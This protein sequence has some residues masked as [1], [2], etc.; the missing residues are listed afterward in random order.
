MPIPFVHKLNVGCEKRNISNYKIDSFKG[1]KAI[2][3]I[4]TVLFSE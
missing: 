1:E 4:S 3:R 2:L